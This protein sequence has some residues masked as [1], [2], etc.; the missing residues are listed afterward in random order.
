MSDSNSKA[1]VVGASLC[2]VAGIARLML[3]RERRQ[4]GDLDLIRVGT[5]KS[6]LAMWQALHVQSELR[7]LHPQT[8]VDVVG[9]L[10][11]GDKDQNTP[12]SAFSDKGVFTKELDTALLDG[13]ID[14]AVHCMKDLPTV[15]PAG[16]AMG[17]ILERGSTE[18]CV[19]MHAKHKGKRLADLPPG[20][21]VGTSAL[22]RIALLAR[23]FPQLVTRDIRGNLNTRLMKLDRG[24]YDALILARTGLQRLQFESRISEVDCSWLEKSSEAC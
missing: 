14:V 1:A 11:T 8:T 20:S 7:R 3:G 10:S 22:R 15:L 6:N 17:P 19:V 21:I 23:K 13:R 24:D 18:D 4:A 12:L 5:R 2:V 9:I 16:I